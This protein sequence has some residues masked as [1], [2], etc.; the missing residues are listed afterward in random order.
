MWREAIVRGMGY[1]WPL[2]R[3]VFRMFEVESK[4]IKA[5]LES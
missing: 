5:G 3:F 2:W 1:W 4:V